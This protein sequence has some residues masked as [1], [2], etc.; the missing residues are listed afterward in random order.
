MIQHMTPS[1]AA[2]EELQGR[3]G[4]F[5][6]ERHVPAL[7]RLKVEARDGTV[8]LRGRVGTF[9]EKALGARCCQRVAGVRRI[10]DAVSVV[11]R[12]S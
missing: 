7:R 10:V 2:D 1:S 6:A 8:T 9:Y 5:L 4:R 3:V 12:G 11:E